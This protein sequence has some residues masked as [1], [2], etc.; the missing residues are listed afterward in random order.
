MNI[1]GDFMEWFDAAEKSGALIS[2]ATAWDAGRRGVEDRLK[3]AIEALRKIGEHETGT[4]YAAEFARDAIAKI[5]GGE[6]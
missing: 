1:K 4:G 2:P 3:I 6:P 5:K